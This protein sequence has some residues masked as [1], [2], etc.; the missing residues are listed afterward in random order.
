MLWSNMESKYIKQSAVISDSF[1]GGDAVKLPSQKLPLLKGHR[2]WP[3]Q[4]CSFRDTF[5]EY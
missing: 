5:G 1:I 4:V 2:C 3:S